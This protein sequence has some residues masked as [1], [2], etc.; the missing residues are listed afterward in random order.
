MVACTL[1][2]DLDR[3]NARDFVPD[4]PLCKWLP[5]LPS[6]S[7]KGPIVQDLVAPTIG[8][9]SLTLGSQYLQYVPQGT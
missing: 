2:F 4:T 9:G 5:W 8:Y 6:L 1:A 3:N 7:H